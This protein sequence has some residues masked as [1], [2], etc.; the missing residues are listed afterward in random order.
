MVMNYRDK[1][2]EAWKQMFEWVDQNRLTCKETTYE[3]L[4]NVATAFLGLFK[5]D[6][7][8][9]AIVRISQ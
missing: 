2:S 5:G 3:G 1:Y 6:N 8:G 4:D 7:I 9:K